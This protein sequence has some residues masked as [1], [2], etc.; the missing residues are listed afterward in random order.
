VG[1][2]GIL[3]GGSLVFLWGCL[4]LVLVFW[5]GSACGCGVCCVCGGIKGFFRWL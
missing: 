2:G 4:G 1:R 5:C 3:C